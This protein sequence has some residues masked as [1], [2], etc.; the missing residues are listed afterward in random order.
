MRNHRLLIVD[1]SNFIRSKI[2]RSLGESGVEIVGLASNGVKAVASFD[3]L[4]P[5]VVTMDVTMPQMDGL[6]CIR[7]LRRRDPKVRILVV[8]ALADKSDAIQALKAG[9][10]GFLCKPFSEQELSEAIHELLED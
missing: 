1:D 6:E 9:A 3:K 2:A 10:Q 7:Q 5:D 8:S 4:R